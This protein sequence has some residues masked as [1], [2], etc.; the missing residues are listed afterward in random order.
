MSSWVGRLVDP[1]LHPHPHIM[2]PV[3]RCAILY[4]A[5]F[6]ITGSRVGGVELSHPMFRHIHFESKR[7][8]IYILTIKP[9]PNPKYPISPL[10]GPTSHVSTL[11]HFSTFCS[12]GFL[13]SKKYQ[14]LFFS[15]SSPS[16]S[17]ISQ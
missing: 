2:S 5:D 15:R 1:H 9:P 17:C 3:D 4:L 16:P 7:S 14:I 12:H 6:S 13:G 8:V 11:S 10:L